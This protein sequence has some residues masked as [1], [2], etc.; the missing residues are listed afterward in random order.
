V[1]ELLLKKGADINISDKQ[2]RTALILAASEGHAATVELLL[3]KVFLCFKK[4]LLVSPLS[5]PGSLLQRWQTSTK[6]HGSARP[7]GRSAACW[8]E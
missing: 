8:C 5:S 2:G 6:R 7:T 4:T 3:A 1:A